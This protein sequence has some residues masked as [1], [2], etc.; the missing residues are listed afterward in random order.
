[1]HTNFFWV[2]VTMAP[3]LGMVLPLELGER[4]RSSDCHIICVEV[5]INYKLSVIHQASIINCW[6]GNT[7]EPDLKITSI[8]KPH[9]VLKS[10]LE[11]VLRWLTL[12]MLG[13]IFSRWHTEIFFLFFPE[14]RFWHFMQ[15]VSIWRQ[16]AW[17]VKSSFL[18]EN[19]KSFINLSSAESP[20]NGK[21]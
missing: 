14:N 1:M 7:T 21:G 6:N 11:T 8:K 15:I 3:F 10:L 2:E 5:G 19:K 4:T 18:G 12:S 20:E 9:P 17:N 13:K 16:F